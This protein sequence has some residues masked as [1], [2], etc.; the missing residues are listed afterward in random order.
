MRIYVSGSSQELVRAEAAMQLVTMTDGVELA[1]DW[2]SEV[3]EHGA[4]RPSGWTDTD[5]V[6]A[7]SSCLSAVSE[8]DVLWLLIPETRSAGCWVELGAAKALGKRCVASG[9]SASLFDESCDIRRPTDLG[10]WAAILGM[11]GASG[12]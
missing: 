3:R 11:V 1:M 10:G 9:I 8:S 6:L 2:V 4:S 7:A 12:D 5:C